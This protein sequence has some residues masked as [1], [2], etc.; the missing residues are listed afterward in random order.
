MTVAIA[1]R[2]PQSTIGFARTF[3]VH[4][5]GLERRNQVA[6]SPPAGGRFLEEGAT[7]CE[8][9]RPM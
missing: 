4:E 7:T 6:A 3:G 5:A 1:A 2:V 9:S 8:G